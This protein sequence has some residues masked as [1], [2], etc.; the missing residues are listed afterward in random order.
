MSH[1]SAFKLDPRLKAD[2]LPLG[3]LPLSRVLL[4]DDARYPWLVLVPRGPGWSELD[5]LDGA[6]RAQ[7]MHEVAL[8]SQ[9]LHD[10]EAVDKINVG[11]L[12]NIVRQL[13]VH[14]V[15]RRVGDPAWPGP[16]WGHGERVP[17]DATRAGR[18]LSALRQRLRHLAGPAFT[19][20]AADQ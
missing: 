2:T 10:G 12:G 18:R 4:M 8:A 17:H 11:A 3:D 5:Q 15:A 14:V 7:L 6:Q 9:A 1:D 16:V 13:H 20:A 19:P